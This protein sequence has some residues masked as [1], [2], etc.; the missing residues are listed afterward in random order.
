MNQL[1]PQEALGGELAKQD[2]LNVMLTGGG[3]YL[4]YFRLY[5]SNTEACQAEK[6]GIAHYGME[7]DGNITD[8]GKE[9]D[10]VILAGRPKAVQTGDNMIVDYHPDVVDG[11]ITNQTFARIMAQSNVKDSGAMYGPELLLWI[12]C[13]NSFV[14]W[15]LNNK[16]A[17]REAKN[18]NID[19]FYGKA[20]T[21]KS[22]FI[23]PETSKFKWHGIIIVEQSAKLE[24]PPLEDIKEQ[25]SKFLDPPRNQVEISTTS[26]E[27][28]R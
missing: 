18:V 27:R 1:V 13:L 16:T 14:T 6:I 9:V 26:D 22:K 23:A 20:A 21:L 24:L 12:P 4:S 19:S 11:K 7:K 8:A 3:D 5:G 2:D 28:A 17:R 15:H 25:I 10:V